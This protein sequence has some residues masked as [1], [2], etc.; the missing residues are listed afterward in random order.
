MT[1]NWKCDNYSISCYT[2]WSRTRLHCGKSQGWWKFRLEKNLAP[3]WQ[4]VSFKLRNCSKFLSIVLVRKYYCYVYNWALD[5]W[6]LVGNSSR[7][8]SFTARWRWI[9]HL[10]TTLDNNSSARKYLIPSSSPVWFHFQWSL[11]WREGQESWQNIAQW[12]GKEGKGT[13]VG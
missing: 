13:T 11:K 3:F 4:S 9:P 1:N 7:D 6:I 12:I 10:S 2:Q 5:F 8:S